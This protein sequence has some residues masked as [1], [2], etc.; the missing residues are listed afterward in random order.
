M[1]PEQVIDE[2]REAGLR[3]RGGAG[4]PDRR[5]VG[6]LPQG[7]GSPKYLICNADEGDPGRVHGPEPCWKATRTR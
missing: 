4:L 5:Q 7:R 6:L 1:T 3:G 2:V